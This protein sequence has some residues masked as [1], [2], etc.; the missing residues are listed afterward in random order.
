MAR[1]ELST[2]ELYEE[3]FG[4][5][6]PGRARH[7]RDRGNTYC[8]RRKGILRFRWEDEPVRPAYGDF[9]STAVWAVSCFGPSS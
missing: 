5:F 4:A 2:V 1:K 8:P 3:G 6:Y 7:L 9:S